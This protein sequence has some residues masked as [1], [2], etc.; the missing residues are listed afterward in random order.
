MRIVACKNCSTAIPLQGDWIPVKEFSLECP[1]CGRRK[2]Y[3]VT[4][5]KIEADKPLA[6]AAAE[7]RG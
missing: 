4:E 3:D 5:I 2:I 6:T 7:N 1:K